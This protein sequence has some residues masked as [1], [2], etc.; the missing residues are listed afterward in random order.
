MRHL[1]SQ[2]PVPAP[3]ANASPAANAPR[4][5]RRKRCRAF[6]ILEVSLAGA[7][8]AMGIATSL[9]VLQYGLRSIDTARNMT[10][11]SQ[12]MQSAIEILR[13]QNWTQIS[14]M[15]T[16]NPSGTP[17]SSGGPAL[18]DPSTTIITSGS[19]SL[20]TT[21]TAI[22]NRFSCYRTV[23]E[24]SGRSDIF[25]I[26]LTVSWTGIDGRAHSLVY[27]TRYAKNGLADYYY[28][29]H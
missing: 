1:F 25:K 23:E 28:V 6:T 17:G 4:V 21:L 14:A 13:L 18:V 3:G 10:L 26:T 9:T 24:I 29:S 15:R 19:S 22:A 16:T 12:I 27:E 5:P 8:M 11:A 7:V 2:G 20:N